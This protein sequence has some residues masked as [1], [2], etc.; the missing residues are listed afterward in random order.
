M[1]YTALKRVYKKRPTLKL[2]KKVT[3]SITTLARKVNSLTK[4]TKDAYEIQFLQNRGLL[5]NISNDYAYINIFN[6]NNCRSIF[7]TVGGDY[8]VC[9]KWRYVNSKMD[10]IFDMGNEYTNIDYS[11]FIVSIKDSANTLYDKT[12]GVIT[13]S[14]GIHYAS[15]DVVSNAGQTILNPRM[16]NI[17]WQKRLLLGNNGYSPATSTATLGQ[18]MG[19]VRRYSYTLKID[20]VIQNVS[21]NVSSLVVSQDPS[22]AYYLLIFNNNASTDLEWQRC[23]YNFTHKL[24]VAN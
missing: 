18:G 19:I 24:R 1:K 2:K 21:G 4:A 15:N 23:S 12:T 22:Q 5:S 9:N 6:Y 7:G 17:H 8:S 10:L 11:L 14:D 16:F 13:L 3:P 20:K